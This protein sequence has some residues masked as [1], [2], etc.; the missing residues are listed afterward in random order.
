MSRS[1]SISLLWPLAVAMTVSWAQAEAAAQNRPAVSVQSITVDGKPVKTVDGVRVTAPGAS[2]PETR[3]LKESDSLAPGT[4][5]EMPARTVVKLIT[6]NS[7][8]ITLQPSSRTKLNAV[9]A[10]GESITQVFGE[11]W[12]KVVRAL[13]FFEV[14]HER[15]LAAVKGTEFKVV[16][17]GGE[18]QFLWVEGQIKVSREV[19]ISV[20]GT[21]QGEPVTLTEDLSAERQRVRY[22]LNVD[23]YLRDFRNYGDVEEYFRNR[24]AEDVRSQDQERILLGWTNLGTALMAI[25]KPK[26]A[27]GFF[28]RSLETH[29]RL[30]PDGVHPAIAGDYAN[31]GMAYSESTDPRRAIRYFEQSLALLLRLYPDG[32]HPHIAINYT[33]LGVAY[34]RAGDPRKAI[35]YFEQSLA[36]LP[37]LYSG[38]DG[39]HPSAV[40]DAAIAANLGNLGG[41]YGRLKEPRRA[42][43]YFEQAL[44]LHRKL[45]PDG[46][47]PDIAVDY[48]NLGVQYLLL[49]DFDKAIDAYDRSLALLLQLYP[50]GVHPSLVQVYRNL[51]SVWQARGDRARADEYARKQKDTE[52][53]L[54]Q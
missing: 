34:G 36:L 54:K 7:T 13:S 8:E 53:K 28:E 37:R 43:D 47:H 40:A 27:I 12:F 16:A 50:N 26:D 32:V 15:F 25:G 20:E 1:R 30:Y 24:L 23:E 42:I 18:I 9:S 2:T 6:A 51:A 52:A 22:P 31:L 21:T 10:N 33:N 3:E 38:P 35:G 11:V 48:N 44:A 49:R 14:A 46:A 45:Y 4:V 5:I 29:L 17:D 41:Q 19:K 39:V